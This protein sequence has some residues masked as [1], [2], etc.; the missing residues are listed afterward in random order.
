[1]PKLFRVGGA[2]APAEGVLVPFKNEVQD[3]QGV[4]ETHLDVLSPGLKLLKSQLDTGVGDRLDILAAAPQPTGEYQPVIVELKNV[5]ATP[6]VLLQCLRYASWVQSSPDSV[7]LYAKELDIT[8]DPSSVRVILVA[9]EIDSSTIEL[10]G[11][12]KGNLDF[13]FVEI[14]RYRIGPEEFLVL[15][16]S[17]AAGPRR[18]GATSGQE[19]WSWERYESELK[20]KPETIAVAKD[21]FDRIQR[22]VAERAWTLVPV[23]RKWYVPF[24]LDGANTI[25][26]E[27]KSQSAV[28]LGV[29]LP[30]PPANLGLPTW[31]AEGQKWDSQFKFVRFPWKGPNESLERWLPYFERSIKE[32]S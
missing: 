13:E 18:V 11:Y 8:V 27:L 31:E 29:R 3:F 12:M 15:D 19:Q 30:E 28:A 22:L 9:P 16:Q 26:V 5:K 1:M 24:Q 4:L 17:H 14:E 6:E 21:L 20:V 25:L 2:A 32:A 10:A 7:R 23:F